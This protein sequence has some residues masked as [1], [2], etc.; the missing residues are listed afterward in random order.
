[1]NSKEICIRILKN[2]F[3]MK[4]LNLKSLVFLMFISLA[5]SSCSSDD[6]SN[7]PEVNNPTA[8]FTFNFTVANAGESVTFTDTSVPGTGA[9]TSWN[10]TFT[11][12]T[13]STST[14]QNPTVIFDSKGEFSVSLN[15]TADDGGTANTSQDI[16][17]V[18]GCDVYDCEKYLV[19]VETNISYGIDAAHNM[20]IYMPK[21]DLR[22]NKPALLLNGGGQFEGS[23]LSV[24]EP[25]AE[26]LAS[27]G[28]VVATASYRN[29]IQDAT[30]NLMRGM[31]DSR[32]AVRFLRANASDYD[33]NPNQIFAGGWASGAY[34]ALTHTYW[35]F[36]DI[37]PPALY[38]FVQ[39]WITGWEGVQGNMGISS[40][41]S[42]VVNL[43]GAMYGTSE[44]YQNDLWITSS[45]V[46]M[47]SVHGTADD[48]TPYGALEL[49]TGNWEF[50]SSIIHQR[51]LDVGVESTL[52]AI[53]GGV[54]ES[55]RLP[56]N[57]DN[58]IEDLVGFLSGE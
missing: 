56:E 19:D 2:L 33:I 41:V 30:G 42:G 40:Q 53:E 38:D 29:G 45:D 32:A 15:V 1:M 14:D 24:L 22:T 43:G 48:E 13:P 4:T 23:D 47:F 36:E 28:F 9:I 31:V 25:L 21:G 5:F 52:Y 6:D 49:E 10:W 18:E 51:L 34:N 50:G 46:P 16:L 20:N 27:Y 3:I 39:Q 11:G 37:D 55:P 44:D 26:R 7:P 57:I 58:Y 17:A 8:S 35:Q 54:H 12:A